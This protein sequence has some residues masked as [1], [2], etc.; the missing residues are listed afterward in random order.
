M[1]QEREQEEPQPT[2]LIPKFCSHW[3]QNS[4]Q[5]QV[6]WFEA[7]KHHWPNADYDYFVIQQFLFLYPLFSPSDT[8]Y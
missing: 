6:I 1:A 5:A 4:L 8:L 7:P 3:I 2:P